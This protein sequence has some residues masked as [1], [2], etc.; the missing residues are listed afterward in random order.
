LHE[1]G[2]RKATDI[3]SEELEMRKRRKLQVLQML[4]GGESSAY[5]QAAE[6]KQTAP[7]KLSA[8]VLVKK[9]KQNRTLTTSTMDDEEEQTNRREF[10]PLDFTEEELKQFDTEP[11]KDAEEGEVG[12]TDHVKKQ[13]LLE[14]KPSQLDQLSSK[15][16]TASNEV[17]RTLASKIPTD[18]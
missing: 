17:L 14:P 4:S 8:A 1:A 3:D 16:N 9:V 18:R 2:K 13:T 10:I 11:N 12:E 7:I 6:A 5:E 15:S